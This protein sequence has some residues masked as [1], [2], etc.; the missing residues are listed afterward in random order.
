MDHQGDTVCAVG[1][2]MGNP[3]GEYSSCPTRCDFPDVPFSLWGSLGNNV[4]KLGQPS[5][6]RNHHDRHAKTL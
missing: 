1:L 3:S 4:V 5:H 2:S 6:R